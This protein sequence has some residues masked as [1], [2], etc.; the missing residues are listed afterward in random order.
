MNSLHCL[1][2]SQA[3]FKFFNCYIFESF[4]SSSSYSFET[5]LNLLHNFGLIQFS[6]HADS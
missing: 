3:C 2:F 5:A 6:P 1:H 4:W